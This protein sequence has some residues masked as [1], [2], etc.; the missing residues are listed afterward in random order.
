MRGQLSFFNQLVCGNYPISPRPMPIY[1]YRCTACQHKLEPLQKFSDAQL[2]VCRSA[3]RRTDQLV[4]AAGFHLKGSGCTDG[5]QERGSKP[6][7]KPKPR[8]AKTKPADQTG[9]TKTTDA[10]PATKSDCARRKAETSAAP[11]AA[12]AAP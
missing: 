9:E 12:A 6:A 5:F 8:P 4:S 10:T 1:E 2:T 11:Q 7:A 3:P